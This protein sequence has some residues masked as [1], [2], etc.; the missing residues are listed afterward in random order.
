L[1][2]ENIVYINPPVLSY[3]SSKEEYVMSILCDNEDKRDLI[4]EFTIEND[5]RPKINNLVIYQSH[6]P[7]KNLNPPFIE[8]PLYTSVLTGDMINFQCIVQNTPATFT[9]ISKPNWLELSPNGIFTGVPFNPGRY[10]TYFT[11]TNEIGPVYYNFT[12]DVKSP[13]LQS[14]E[15]Y[16]Y[17]QGY[18][19]PE[20]DDGFVL[21]QAELGA[22]DYKI[23][24][25]D[26]TPMIYF[27]TNGYFNIP[28]EEDSLILCIEKISSD[29]EVILIM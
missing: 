19:T 4:L 5:Y 1:T 16:L 17:T 26:P 2:S 7:Q 14:E 23:I 29:E 20:A 12:V 27:Y 21:Q 6:P 25:T 18:Y 24:I 22:E 10:E 13:I 11:V 28:G 3:N 8:H 15:F 9:I